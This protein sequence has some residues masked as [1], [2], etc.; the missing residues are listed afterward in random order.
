MTHTHII[1]VIIIIVIIELDAE[2]VLR[3]ET[4]ATQRSLG[5]NVEILEFVCIHTNKRDRDFTSTL[6]NLWI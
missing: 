2:K 4:S 1:V 6:Q 5:K 3:G